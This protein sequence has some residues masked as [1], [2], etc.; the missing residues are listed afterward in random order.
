MNYKIILEMGA[1]RM[2]NKEKLNQ[3]IEQD[4]NWKDC[5][6]EIIRKIE[7]GA[8][9]TK[10]NNSWK[11]SLVPICLVVIISGVLFLNN[12]NDNKT[13]LEN[14]PFVEEKNNV[15]LNINEIQSDQS[16]TFLDAA[17]DV[18]T[19]TANDVNFPLPYEYEINL[20]KDLNK[21][22]R[23]IVYT[24][25]NTNSKEY[26]ILNSYSIEYTNDFERTI[27]VAYSKEYKPIRD[28]YFSEEG[29]K[30]TTINGVELKIYKFEDIYFTEFNY[31]GYNVDIE[32]SKITEQEL[33]TFLLSIVK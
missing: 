16:G 15:T 23:S 12:Q 30:S 22:Y 4:M 9:M 32:T 28:Y 2:T 25:E 26:N 8:K 7:E 33:S 13:K 18:K 6:N 14:K 3:A 21:T 20:P 17:I 10:K 11:W 19:V 24:R 5:Y 1:T 29:N 31:K 27:K